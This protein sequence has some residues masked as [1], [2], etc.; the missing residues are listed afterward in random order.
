MCT[1]FRKNFVCFN[2]KDTYNVYDWSIH[3]EQAEE[4]L[5][6]GEQMK[7]FKIEEFKQIAE[8]LGFE[9]RN[10]FWPFSNDI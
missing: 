4:A 6:K 3:N 10:D 9:V 5:H 8:I 2:D 7:K 1:F